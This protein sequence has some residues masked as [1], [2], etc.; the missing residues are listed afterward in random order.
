MLTANLHDELVKTRKKFWVNDF[1]EISIFSKPSILT[2]F[3]KK[4][5]NFSNI[6][7]FT[8]KF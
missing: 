3:V 7:Y 1:Q 6:D 4:I 5:V 8:F 2:I